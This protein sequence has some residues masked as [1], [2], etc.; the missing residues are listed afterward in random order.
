MNTQNG[1]PVN[2]GPKYSL[3][4]SPASYAYAFKRSQP[5]VP[6]GTCG[7]NFLI[8]SFCL[9]HFL[10]IPCGR[11][12]WLSGS[13]VLHVK[14]KVSYRTPGRER[15]GGAGGKRRGGQGGWVGWD[16]MSGRDCAVLK[17]SFKKL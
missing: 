1:I 3:P 10:F 15:R 6:H 2:G 12:S 16:G 9:L 4:S 13:F 11:L 14:Y 8:F 5:S 7:T 17:N